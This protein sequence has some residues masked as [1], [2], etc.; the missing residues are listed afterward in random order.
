LMKRYAQSI[1][2]AFDR[3]AAGFDAAKKGIALAREIG[4]DVRATILPEDVKDPD[5]LV[6]RDPESWRELVGASVPIMEFLIAYTTRGKDLRNID[7]KRAVAKELLP[8][9]SQMQTVVE[10]EH[11][12]QVVADLLSIDIKELRKAI[13]LKKIKEVKKDTV[14]KVAVEKMSKLEKARRLLFGWSTG[15]DAEFKKVSERLNAILGEDELW[16][17]LYNIAATTY[18]STSQLAQKSYF[19]RIREALEGHPKQESLEALL[20]SSTLMAEQIFHNLP[21]QK[22][23][24]HI[25][26]LFTLLEESALKQGRDQ[27]ARDLRLAEQAGDTAAVKRLLEKLRERS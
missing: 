13:D 27:L 12:L 24:E 9:I 3:D 4:L 19:S 23:L 16:I 5:E 21:S 26:T 7:D 6:Q 8:A 17:T 22:V 1:I 25:E 20:D 2:F 18:D 11:W 15:A 10:R 14:K